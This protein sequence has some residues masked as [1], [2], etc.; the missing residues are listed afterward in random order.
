MIFSKKIDAAMACFI[1]FFTCSASSAEMACRN[2]FY[3]INKYDQIEVVRFE[4]QR[5]EPKRSQGQKIWLYT[6]Q[7]YGRN[8]AKPLGSATEILGSIS[9]T[10]REK[11]IRIH[12]VVDRPELE[13][14]NIFATLIDDVLRAHPEV[15][16][17]SMNV[18]SAHMSLQQMELL[19]QN[20]IR[21]DIENQFLN[22]I[23]SAGLQ[24]ERAQMISVMDQ[25]SLVLV[26]RPIL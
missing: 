26:L 4:V 19:A 17:I 18:G 2:V 10:I 3:K 8:T 14:G 23:K 15:V 12:R 25:H 1:L 11:N 16:Q 7:M 24:I 6:S 13:G 20:P 22:V 9:Y 21:L 5:S